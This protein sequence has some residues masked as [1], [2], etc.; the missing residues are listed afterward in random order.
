M[1][2]ATE[3]LVPPCRACGSV[4]WNHDCIECLRT[5]VRMMRDAI[6]K[7]GALLDDYNQYRIDEDEVDVALRILNEWRRADECAS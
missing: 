4:N 3:Q 5:E 2:L 6:E 1:K 7:A